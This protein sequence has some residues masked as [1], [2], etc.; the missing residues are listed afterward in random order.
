[1]GNYLQFHAGTKS[2]GFSSGK[3]LKVTYLLCGMWKWTVGSRLFTLLNAA[4]H[5]LGAPGRHGDRVL[6]SGAYHLWVFNME[7]ASRH[8]SSA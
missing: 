2:G 6:Y 7:S 4:A 5:Q 8:N 1:V 3:Q